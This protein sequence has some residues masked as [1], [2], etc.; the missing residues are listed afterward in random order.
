MNHQPNEPS[1]VFQFLKGFQ[2]STTDFT[3]R[4]LSRSIAV[5]LIATSTIGLVEPRLQ[6]ADLLLTD[7]FTSD[8]KMNRR[9]LRGDWLISA[10]V[11]ACVQDDTLYKKYKNHGPIIFYDLPYDDVSVRF[12]IKPQQTK[13]VV[14]TAN[15][16]DGHIFRAVWAKSGLTVR[17]FPPSSQKKSISVG[18]SPEAIPSENE[19]LPI[20]IQ[21][22]GETAI[23]KSGN[24]VLQAEHPSFQR[25][26]LNLSV[27]FSFG[28][29]AVKDLSVTALSSP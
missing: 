14:F 11:A 23:I 22:R 16:A 28:S 26:K 8:K 7:G 4:T 9:A 13:T 10:G 3:C 15:G 29:L 24:K 18:K 21:L 25:P 27:G 20:E 6:A 19:W 17:A 12:A 1:R 5:L 2:M